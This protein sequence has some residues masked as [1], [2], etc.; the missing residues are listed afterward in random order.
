MTCNDLLSASLFRVFLKVTGCF[1]VPAVSKEG[2]EFSLL[3]M[4]CRL[5]VSLHSPVAARDIGVCDQVLGSFSSP[6]AMISKENRS[7]TDCSPSQ[8]CSIEWFHFACVGLTTKPR[9]KW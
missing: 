5:G 8:Q 9:G 1:L 4:M 6:E 2:G 3:A 7:L